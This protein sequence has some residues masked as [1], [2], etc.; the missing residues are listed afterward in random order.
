MPDYHRYHSPVQ[1]EVKTYQSLPGD[2]YQVD[3]VALQSKVD[4]L[5]RNRRD[6]VVI[7]T[8]EFGNVLFAAVGATDVGSVQYVNG[9]AGENTI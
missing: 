5:T 8:R 1:G 2:C 7:E 4:F 3:P 9:P 6:H